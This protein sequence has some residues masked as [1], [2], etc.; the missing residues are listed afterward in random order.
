MDP[1]K[2]A[3]LQAGVRRGGKGT[4][5]RRQ[6]ATLKMGGGGGGGDRHV[7]EALLNKHKTHQ[8]NDIEEV[9][10]FYDDGTVLRFDNKPIQGNLYLMYGVILKEG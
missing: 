10:M 1:A 9:N 2:L 5:R 3:K 8:L 4:P 6:L 7:Q